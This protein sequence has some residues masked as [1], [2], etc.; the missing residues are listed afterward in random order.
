MIFATDLDNTMIF[1]N[2]RIVGFEDEVRCVEYYKGRPLTF[3]THSSIAKLE[4]LVRKI[5]VV[6]I[7]TRSL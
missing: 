1:S 2:R 4:D 7:T 3:M 6:P 5:D